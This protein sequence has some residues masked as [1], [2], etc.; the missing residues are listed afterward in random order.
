[1]GSCNLRNNRKFF[2]E[3][4]NGQITIMDIETYKSLPYEARLLPKTNIVLSEGKFDME[5]TAR[6]EGILKIVMTP[7]Q[8]LEKAQNVPGE[9][10]CIFG[11][12]E[13]YEFFLNN[14][15]FDELYL[16]PVNEWFGSSVTFPE[17]PISLFDNYDQKEVGSFKKGVIDNHN[18]SIY[19]YKKRALKQKTL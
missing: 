17:L 3:T 19:S 4:I 10:I 11:N 18:Y 14:T 9:K 6:E 13:I 7:W 2:R 1:M 12:K 15:V 5:V 16:S 8:A